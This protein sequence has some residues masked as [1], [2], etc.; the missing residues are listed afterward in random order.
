MTQMERGGRFIRGNY[1]EFPNSCGGGSAAR[2][3]AIIGLA[4]TPA[5]RMRVWCILAVRPRVLE[6]DP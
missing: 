2:M 5:C 1:S 6:V 3:E 4:F